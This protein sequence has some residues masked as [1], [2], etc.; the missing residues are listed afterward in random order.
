MLKTVEDIDFKDKKVFIRVD[1]NVPIDEKTG[2]IT[3]DFRIKLTVPTI[4]FILK[5]MPKQVIFACHAGRPKNNEPYLK[6]DKISELLGKLIDMPIK[7]IDD[8]NTS[9]H[10]ANNPDNCL[11]MLEN[12]RFNPNEK[13][14][15]Q[16]ERDE[17]GKLLAKHMDVF[18]EDAFSNCHRDHASMTSVP[19]F[20]EEKCVGLLIKK[21]LDMIKRTIENPKTPFVSIIGG[22]KADKLSAIQNLFKT[23]D[24]ILLGGSLGF[25]FCKVAGN[26]IGKTKIDKEGFTEDNEFLIKEFLNNPKITLPIDAVVAETPESTP[27]VVDINQIQDNQMA[28]DIGPKTI[29][30]YRIIIQQAETISWNG[31][32]GMYEKPEFADGTKLIADAMAETNATT[33]VGGGDSAA[34]LEKF[35]FDKHMTHVSTGGGAS[36]KLFEGKELIALKVLEE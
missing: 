14:E 19:K 36:L 29:E 25:L 23:A 26:N 17:F 27:E 10:D 13:S 2:E 1:Y 20:V 4:N 21:E 7:K 12:L 35:G 15:L 33:I 3:N 34:A 5:Q 16:E 24:K 28:L 22:I 11:I 8:W 30:R 31:P 9:N 18:V 6:T 32:M